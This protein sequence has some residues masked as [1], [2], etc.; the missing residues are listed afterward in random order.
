MTDLRDALVDIGKQNDNKIKINKELTKESIIYA[1]NT[2][3]S[4]ARAV[5]I[6]DVETSDHKAFNNLNGL[7]I[8]A[9]I[10]KELVVDEG[11]TLYVNS[12]KFTHRTIETPDER[13]MF[14]A[15][16]CKKNSRGEFV[17]NV[18]E[19]IHAMSIAS[20]LANRNK[21]G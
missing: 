16:Y 4:L 15:I 1:A 18:S 6:D 8:S 11:G 17:M 10:E 21:L 7:K 3:N 13:G 12:T 9:M 5:H 2:S 19:G 14:A 20:M